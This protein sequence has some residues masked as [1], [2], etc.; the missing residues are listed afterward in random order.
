MSLPSNHMF[1]TKSFGG[2][3]KA[4]SLFP[5]ESFLLTVLDDNYR[6]KNVQR[7][8]D[9]F[10]FRPRRDSSEHRIT[11]PIDF[12]ASGPKGD[13][14]WQMQFHGWAFFK[15]MVNVFDDL[16]EANQRKV[17]SLFLRAARDWWDTF[18]LDRDD[19][20]PERVPDTYVWYDMSVALR[21]LYVAFF[22][23]RINFHRLEI[24]PEERDLVVRLAAKHRRNLGNP[25][26]FSLNNHGIWQAHAL[27]MLN[28][29]FGFEESG[30]RRSSLPVKMMGQLVANQF[31]SNGIHRE[32]SPHYHFFA[33]RAFEQATST[34]LY[35]RRLT[36][37]LR[38][39]TDVG[40]WLVDPLKRPVLVGDSLLTVQSHVDFPQ[41]GGREPVVSDLRK[42]GIAI[43]R[44]NWSQQ[45][46]ASGMVYFMNAFHSTVHKHR[47]CLSFEW[48]DRGRRLVVDGGKY[49][50]S[51]DK[52]RH[53]LLQ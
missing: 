12:Q 16:K 26:T 29:V 42:S 8:I 41:S 33:L 52:F 44:S 13:R 28:L 49:G 10:L 27:M 22:W 47:D 25:T 34:G 39:A 48:F 38:A 46:Q 17:L 5:L 31:D 15:P 37:R 9:Q 43:V 7:T 21:A 11:C 2:R 40:K 35:P 51:K 14:N 18:S 20:V 1:R 36:K 30:F 53:H 50:Y 23:N 3:G 6:Q 45:P 32:H 24:E 19:V 4:Y